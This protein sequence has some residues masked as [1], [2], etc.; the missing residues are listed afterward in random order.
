MPPIPPTPTYQAPVVPPPP[1]K[2]R[3]PRSMLGRLTFAAVLVGVGVLAIF[4]TAGAVEPSGRHY[5]GLALLITAVGLMV[6]TIWG[7]SRAL[8]ALGFVLLF[9][10]GGA[11]VTDVVT[12]IEA[13]TEIYAPEFVDEIASTYDLDAGHLIL[14]FTDV[15]LAGE[16][17]E[18]R[19]DIGVGKIEVRLAEEQGADVEARTGI[20]RVEVF[21][22][23][24][25]G[26][27]VGR[28]DDRDG[29]TG[30]LILDLDAGIGEIVVTQEGR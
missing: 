29:T 28:S 13:T 23:S 16:S 30:T 9:A 14:D 20:G 1:P 10:M 24:S 26:L 22:R 3:R 8:I 4:D 11:V 25:E 12:D 27:G 5:L 15:D 6:G 18:V 17:L 7:R 21:G 2:P 19:A